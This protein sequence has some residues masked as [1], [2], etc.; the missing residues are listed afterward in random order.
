MGFITSAGGTITITPGGAN[1]SPVANTAITL[2]AN[3]SLSWDYPVVCMLGPG[4]IVAFTA[5][6]S[7]VVTQAKNVTGA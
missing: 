4:T 5:M 3:G 7:V 1:Q 6:D 2:P